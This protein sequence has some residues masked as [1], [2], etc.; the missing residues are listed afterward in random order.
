MATKAQFG[1]LDQDRRKVVLLMNPKAGA[2]SAADKVNALKYEL[3]EAGFETDV[4]TDLQEMSQVAANDPQIRCIVSCGGDGT[5]TAV[6]NGIDPTMPVVIYPLG[7]ENVLAKYLEVTSDAAEVAQTVVAGRWVQMDVGMAGDR[8]FL[9]HVGCGFD[10]DVVRRLHNERTGHIQKLSY[11]KPIFESIRK[12]PYPELLVKY[13]PQPGKDVAQPA[14]EGDS[15]SNSGLI[16]CR[17]AFVVNLPRYAGG[18]H[19]VEEAVAT[20]GLLDICTFRSG[21][22]LS[23]LWYLG[24][25]LLGQH[26]KSEDCI[27]VQT[28]K[29][30]LESTGQVPYQLDGDP[31]GFLPV[32]IEIVP[33]RLRLVVP[34][35]WFAEQLQEETNDTTQP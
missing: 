14:A 4:L 8:L 27:T 5:A 25:I 31:G 23:G 6:A 19:F 11:A 26:R 9:L 22:L 20:D 24:S 7:T 13:E 21:S 33:G 30:R 17:W 2:T 32:D 10:A 28:T 1:M 18:L 29:L 15:A 35:K 16:R 12:Y 34:E 3:E